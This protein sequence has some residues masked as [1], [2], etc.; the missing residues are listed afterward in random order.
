M[1]TYEL[2]DESLYLGD[3]ETDRVSGE[4]SYSVVQINIIPHD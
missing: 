1:G 3:W 4:I 2:F